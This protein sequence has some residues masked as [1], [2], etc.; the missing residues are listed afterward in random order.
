MTLTLYIIG[1]YMANEIYLSKYV[2]LVCPILTD[3]FTDDHKLENMKQCSNLGITINQS[4][5]HSFL[6]SILK[7]LVKLRTKVL[8]FIKR[9][10]HKFDQYIK[11]N[12]YISLVQPSLEC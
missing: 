11:S 9:N 5:C 2:I 6:T 3:Y 8:N 10:L 7:S 1:P 4:L 12:V